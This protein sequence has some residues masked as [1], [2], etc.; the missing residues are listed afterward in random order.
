[1]EMIRKWYLP[2]GGLLAEIQ[3]AEAMRQDAWRDANERAREQGFECAVGRRLPM[4]YKPRDGQGVPKGFRL[5][6]GSAVPDQRTKLGKLEAGWLKGIGTLTELAS[7][8]FALAG[9]IGYDMW[10]DR[11]NGRVWLAVTWA[12]GV[13]WKSSKPGYGDDSFHPILLYSDDDGET[14][15]DPIDVVEQLKDPR[16]RSVW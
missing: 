12:K 6:N 1:M 4:A 13:H 5:K 7:S 11:E 15:S 3:I 14:W 16:W 2:T 9:R 8:P 10:K